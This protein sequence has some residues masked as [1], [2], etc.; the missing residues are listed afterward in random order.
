MRRR[1]G[2]M[3]T[4]QAVGS[5]PNNDPMTNVDE[6]P[7][8][9]EW[10]TTGGGTLSATA[11]ESVT[12]TAPTS[13]GHCH[14]KR[15]RQG[16]WG[17]ALQPSGAKNLGDPVRRRHRQSRCHYRVP[18]CRCADRQAV[19]RSEPGSSTVP[20]NRPRL[21]S[22]STTKPEAPAGSQPR[23]YDRRRR[24]GL[25]WRTTPTTSRSRSP[26]TPRRR[27]AE[28]IFMLTSAPTSGSCRSCRVLP[29]LPTLLSRLTPTSRSCRSRTQRRWRAP[30][31]SSP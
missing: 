8:T 13:T 3:I 11:G 20:S 2:G 21:I 10:T 4:F 22:K 5:D 26:R 24:R 28:P 12:W 1:L 31:W 6:D 15:R 23:R 27:S 29:T 19:L 9:Y 25:V 16:C 30:R 14:G 17:S 7:L 18:G